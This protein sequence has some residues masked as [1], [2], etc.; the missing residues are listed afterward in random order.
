MKI[1]GGGGGRTIP[2]DLKSTKP[3]QSTKLF[4]M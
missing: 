2:E 1:K 3:K 4:K